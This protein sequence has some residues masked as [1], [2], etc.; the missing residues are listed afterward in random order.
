MELKFNFAI[1]K[2]YVEKAS[3]VFMLSESKMILTPEEIKEKNQ[4]IKEISEAISL[5]EALQEIALDEIRLEIILETIR[6]E[7]FI[8]A[9]NEMRQEIIKTF[10][11]PVPEC[12]TIKDEY[13]KGGNMFLVAT[14][15]IIFNGDE[16]ITKVLNEAV[17]K[18]IENW[19]CG[20]DFD[21]IHGS[22]F[23]EF[24]DSTVNRIKR[25]LK[26]DKTESEAVGR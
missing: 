14:D 26:N 3:L 4:H 12:F 22:N 21:M 11:I 25:Y 19:T 16:E 13:K 18:S 1:N 17:E 8:K 6:H 20:N 15:D 7:G 24:K 2:L 9:R 23:K 5:M 10:G